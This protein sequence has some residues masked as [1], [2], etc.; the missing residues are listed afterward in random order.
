MAPSTCLETSRDAISSVTSLQDLHMTGQNK[1]LSFVIEEIPQP[2]YFQPAQLAH[3][4]QI[5]PA[6]LQHQMQSTQLTIHLP[7]HKVTFK[8]KQ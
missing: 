3:V 1:D 2:H 8:L 6:R 4:H 7:A 5:H